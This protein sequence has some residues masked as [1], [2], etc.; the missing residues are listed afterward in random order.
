MDVGAATPLLVVWVK[1]PERTG[2]HA[3]VPH[4]T[5]ILPR[6]TDEWVMRLPPEAL[7]TRCRAIGSTAW[8]DRVLTPV[9][10]VPLF[11]WQ[12][13]HGNTA[14][15]HLPP[16]SGLRL[17]A[18]ASGHARATRPRRCC[19]LLRERFGSA[20]QHSALDD[21]RWDGHRPCLVDG[22]G[23]AMPETP[24]LQEAFGQPSAQRPGC[25]FPV[26]RLL[27]RFQAGTGVLLTRVVAPLLTHDLA[28]VQAV[29]PS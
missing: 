11:L 12:M 10:T 7:L 5:T 15:R 9:T 4:L 22:S 17:S 28:R 25:G 16:L 29:H 18:A 19:A 3:L 23:C 8:C 14:C 26:A 13:L 2:G 20:V 21:G 1:A 24:T 6:F 27:G